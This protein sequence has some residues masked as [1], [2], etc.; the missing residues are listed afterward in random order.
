MKMENAIFLIAKFVVSTRAMSQ[1]DADT[2]GQAMADASSPWQR[3]AQLTDNKEA[4][5][6]RFD[7]WTARQSTPTPASATHSFQAVHRFDDCGRAIW[8]RFFASVAETP[9]ALPFAPQSAVLE[10]Q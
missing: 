5:V 10:T 2:A 7:A 6:D 8:N 9:A 1:N 4:R 3:C